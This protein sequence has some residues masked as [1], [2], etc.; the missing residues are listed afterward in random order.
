VVRL[1]LGQLEKGGQ[2]T[3]MLRK[4]ALNQETRIIG[5]DQAGKRW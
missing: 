1:E 4:E 3:G 5:Y 2:I